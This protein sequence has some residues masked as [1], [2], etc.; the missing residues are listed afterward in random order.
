MAGGAALDGRKEKNDRSKERRMK[1]RCATTLHELNA[2]I[3]QKN[4]PVIAYF[5]ASWAPMCTQTDAIL[6][7]LVKDC[8]N[9]VFIS[10]EAEESEEIVDKYEVAS[11]PAFVSIEVS[12]QASP[13]RNVTRG[14]GG[15]KTGIIVGA[16]APEI[17]KMAVQ[18]DKKTS[19][20][21]AAPVTTRSHD[22]GATTAPL[23]LNQRLEKLVSREP[24]MLFMKGSPGAERCGF[25]RQI[26]SILEQQGVKYGHFDILEDE[27]VRQG[28]KEYSKWPTYPQLYSKGKLVGGLDI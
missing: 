10:I 2:V 13:V 12:Q 11:V 14:Q 6:N 26:V 17:S 16:N 25:S 9:V 21:S 20:S 18:L 3:S 8:P 5:R 1:H 24:V 28:L 22:E 15:K 7:Q 19:G 4:A 27:E 23:P